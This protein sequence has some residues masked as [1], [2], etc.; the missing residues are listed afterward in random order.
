M[1]RNLD[2]LIIGGESSQGKHKARPFN[3]A[4]ARSTVAQCRVAGVPVFV[5][6][7]GASPWFGTEK[8]GEPHIIMVDCKDRAG[9]IPAEWP[10]DLRIQEFPA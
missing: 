10:P 7:L 3:I 8:D 1:L 2:W 9:A 4:W 6:Q 5:K